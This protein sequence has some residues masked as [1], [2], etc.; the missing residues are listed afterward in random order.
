MFATIE[1]SPYIHVQGH[2]RRLLSGGR[3]VIES[4]GREYVGLL[5]ERPTGLRVVSSR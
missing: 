2:V 1:L 4:M 5:T 3:A